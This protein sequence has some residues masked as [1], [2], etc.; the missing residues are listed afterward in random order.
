[1][2]LNR[3][4]GWL[5]VCLLDGLLF[6]WRTGIIFFIL[7]QLKNEDLYFFRR[8]SQFPI[9]PILFFFSENCCQTCWCLLENG[10]CTNNKSPWGA[11][12][13]VIK[14][15]Q[16]QRPKKIKFKR[17]R[18]VCE[19]VLNLRNTVVFAYII[20]YINITYFYRFYYLL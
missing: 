12:H 15:Y 20:I 1:M 11:R 10:I 7:T 3:L 5:I 17:P 14:Q 6:V 8:A 18:R 9:I 19:H 4:V 2:V 16:V 13:D